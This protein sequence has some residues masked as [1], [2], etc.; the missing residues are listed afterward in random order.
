MTVTHSHW[1]RFQGRTPPPLSQFSFNN[2]AIL[3]LF[4]LSDF[5]HLQRIDVTERVRS[6]MSLDDVAREFAGFEKIVIV[7]SLKRRWT[8]LFGGE[9]DPQLVDRLSD[10]QYCIME[11][12]GRS[13][14]TFWI[15]SLEIIL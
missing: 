6:G 3:N 13:R 4:Q 9:A 1:Q 12:I 10:I 8:A 14:L 11:R 7:A 15:T 2:V 5:H